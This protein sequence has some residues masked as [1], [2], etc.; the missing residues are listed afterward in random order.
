MYAIY[1]GNHELLQIED[2]LYNLSFVFHK[3]LFI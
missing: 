1:L 2:M 3:M